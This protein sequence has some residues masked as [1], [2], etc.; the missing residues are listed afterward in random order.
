MRLSIP[1]ARPGGTLGTGFALSGGAEGGYNRL[2]R[3]VLAAW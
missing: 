3:L 2:V 1:Q